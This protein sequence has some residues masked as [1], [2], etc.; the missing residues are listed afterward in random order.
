LQLKIGLIQKFLQPIAF[1]QA[2]TEHMLGSDLLL[3]QLL[4]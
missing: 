1:L 2:L 4:A 3:G